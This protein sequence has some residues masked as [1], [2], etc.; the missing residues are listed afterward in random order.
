MLVPEGTGSRRTVVGLIADYFSPREMVPLL[1]SPRFWVLFA[2]ASAPLVL[3]AARV[4]EPV[5]WLFFYFSLVWAV[6]FEQ[7]V[8]PER[9]TGFLAVPLY[10][11]TVVVTVPALLAYL[12]MPPF[13]TDALVGSSSIVLQAVG[14][15][16]GVGLREEA[17][18]LLPLLAL[19]VL[20]RARGG[21]LSLRQGLFLGVVCGVAF[22]AAEN[23]QY[24][25]QFE[26]HD[27]LAHHLGLLSD[28]TLQGTMNRLLLTPFMHG[29]WSGIAG[30]FLVWGE[31]EPRARWTFR[32]AG[33]GGTAVLHGAY[34]LS[35]AAPA[36][37]LLVVALSFH[38]FFRCASR[39][40]EPG[41]HGVA[42]RR[43]GGGES[44]GATA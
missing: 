12:S 21:P 14:L 28:E 34:D 8:Q 40:D 37:A 33:V 20:R 17:F 13:V 10:A 26:A 19:V 23:V 1:L 2:L 44:Q 16:L 39:A 41:R 22:A 38:V 5:S 27:R 18:K 25:A 36:F 15:V 3:L 11:A 6:I 24:L 43:P 30:Y 29:A 31:R 35:A 4:D 32:L 9:G 7:I 42:L